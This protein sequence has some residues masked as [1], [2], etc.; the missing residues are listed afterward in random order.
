MQ[1]F[2]TDRLL[3]RPLRLDDLDAIYRLLDLDL[4]WTV[5]DDPAADALAERRAWLEWAVLNE[6]VLRKLHQPPY[7]ERA[8]VLKSSGEL[9]GAAGFVPCLFPFAQLPSYGGQPAPA[10]FT[11]EV[12]LFWAIGTTHQGQGYATEAAAALIGYGF[13]ELNLKRIV[14]TTS[15]DNGASAAVMRRLGMRVERNPLSEPP[16][17][18]I[19]ATLDHPAN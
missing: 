10:R 16:W 19:V 18:Q 2:Q 9:V 6:A 3:I 12:G 14:A 4:G 11:N 7:G 8:V 17:M 5:V 13:A 1:D 15:Y